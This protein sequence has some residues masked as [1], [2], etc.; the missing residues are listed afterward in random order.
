M[1]P[2]RHLRFFARGAAVFLVLFG[3][4]A[5]GPQPTLQV[6]AEYQLGQKHFHRICANCHGP[7]AMGKTTKAP[8]LIDAEYLPGNFPDEEIRQTVI[9]GTG[10]MPSQRAKVTDG[11]IAEI[12]KYLRYSQKSAGIVEDPDDEEEDEEDF[13]AV[14]DAVSPESP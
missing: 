11:E 8:R 4:A 12:I 5:C 7:D 1:K 9:E 2:I 13:A 14:E 6:P 3:L 10:K